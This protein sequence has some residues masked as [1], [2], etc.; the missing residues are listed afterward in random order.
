MAEHSTALK[1]PLIARAQ[2]TPVESEIMRILLT[3][4]GQIVTRN[5]L[6]QWLDRAE[7]LYGDRKFDVHITR[8]RKKLRAAYGERFI[9]HTIRAKGYLVE[10]TEDV[11]RD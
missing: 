7:W 11:A 9:V 4:M 5:Q 3:H 1:S 6:S 8:I 2:L 10:I